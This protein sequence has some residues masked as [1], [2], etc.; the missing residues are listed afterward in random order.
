MIGH[1]TVKR[2]INE[3][4]NFDYKAKQ[5][6]DF[7]DLDSDNFDIEQQKLAP[8]NRITQRKYLENI[9]PDDVS[10]VQILKHMIRTKVPKCSTKLFDKLE[11]SK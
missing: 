5:S 2:K 11:V 4:P 3:L 10:L 6:Q 9:I 8:F 1:C 7:Y